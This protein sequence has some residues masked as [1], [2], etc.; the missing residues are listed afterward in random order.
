VSTREGEKSRRRDRGSISCAY[1]K[2]RRALADCR[3]EKRKR[4]RVSINLFSPDLA[5]PPNL[6]CEKRIVDSD[7][8]RSIMSLGRARRVARPYEEKGRRRLL[9]TKR[10]ASFLR[11]GETV[12]APATLLD[13]K[14][15][16]ESP[17]ITGSRHSFAEGKPPRPE[18]E[19]RPRS[20]PKR[21]GQAD[22]G[23]G[24]RGLA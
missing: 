8:P 1:G 14:R 16:G 22:G 2:D 10:A 6:Q 9:G 17:Q 19:S 7:S 5:L 23:R 13:P 11:R 24:Q 21:K 12:R 18:R 15:S 3:R 20:S 4:V